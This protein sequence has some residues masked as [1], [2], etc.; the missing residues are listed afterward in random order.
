MQSMPPAVPVSVEVTVGAVS[1][2]VAIFVQ[3]AAR[4]C[5]VAVFAA[6]NWLRHPVVAH[7]VAVTLVEAAAD[8]TATSRFPAPRICPVP[9]VAVT[10]PVAEWVFTGVPTLVTATGQ[11]LPCPCMAKPPVT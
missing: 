2:P 7:T 11:P 6:S 9:H 5:A 8:T 3:H 4:T 10:D 1:A